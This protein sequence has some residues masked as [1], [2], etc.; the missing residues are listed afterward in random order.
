MFLRQKV[1]MFLKNFNISNTFY[2]SKE[3]ICIQCVHCMAGRAAG[4][5]TKRDGLPV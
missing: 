1:S 4:L 2:C 5:A 3:T